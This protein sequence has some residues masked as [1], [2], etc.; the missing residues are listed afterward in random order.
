MPAG[1]RTGP[2]SKGPKTGRGLGFCAGHDS[3]GFTKGPRR[4]RGRG[5]RWRHGWRGEKGRGRGWGRGYGQGRQWRHRWRDWNPKD[6]Q[7]IEE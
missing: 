6:D 3:P 4:G 1:D 7:N 5:Y 2:R